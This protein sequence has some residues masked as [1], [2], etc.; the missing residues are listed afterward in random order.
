LKSSTNKISAKTNNDKLRLSA[1]CKKLDQMNGS[2][3]KP[4]TSQRPRGNCVAILH[5]PTSNSAMMKKLA[6]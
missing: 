3:I 6:L 5:A 4:K 2:A 1:I